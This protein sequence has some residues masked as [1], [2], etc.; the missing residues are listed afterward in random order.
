MVKMKPT[1]TFLVKQWAR[2][3]PGRISTS[4]ARCSYV[5]WWLAGNHLCLWP[6]FHTCMAL[7]QSATHFQV[8]I[9]KA[10]QQEGTP[11]CLQAAG[12]FWLHGCYLTCWWLTNRQ[13]SQNWHHKP[14]NYTS[15]LSQLYLTCRDFYMSKK[16]KPPLDLLTWSRHPQ[17]YT[18]FM[19]TWKNVQMAT[20]TQTSGPSSPAGCAPRCTCIT[21]P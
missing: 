14:W 7:Y 3:L 4:S 1:V 21:T 11:D 5:R 12:H 17:C 8:E 18:I 6:C 10:P 16:K 2:F 13:R 19:K 9:S 15:C 20:A